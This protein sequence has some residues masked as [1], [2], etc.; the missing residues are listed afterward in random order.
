MGRTFSFRGKVLLADNSV[1]ANHQ[2]MDYVS[3]DRTKAW[4]VK[5]AYIW[6]VDWWGVSIGGTGFLSLA[7]AL[8]TDTGKF[9]QNE[10]T[11]PSENRMFAWA[12]QT[13][14]HRNNNALFV[15]PNATPLGRMNML[16]DPDHMITKELYISVGS[17]TD[18][19]ENALR[20]IGYLIIVEEEKVSPSTSVFQQIKGMGQ[21]LDT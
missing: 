9:N 16:V 15:T 6:V 11:D 14:N 2:I 4:R 7:G 5:E 18:I 17:A 12:H 8:S 3:P 21:D 10:L 19:D 20:E 13:Y 1:T